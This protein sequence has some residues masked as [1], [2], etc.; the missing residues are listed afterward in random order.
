MKQE[1]RDTVGLMLEH[2]DDAASY[3]IEWNGILLYALDIAPDR[4]GEATR[5]SRTAHGEQGLAAAVE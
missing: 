3:G 4:D 1:V 2:P 5:T